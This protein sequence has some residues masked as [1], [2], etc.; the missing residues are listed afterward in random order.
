MM[1]FLAMVIVALALSVSA[2]AQH[3]MTDADARKLSEA[4]SDKFNEDWNKGD[5]KQLASLFTRDATLVTPGG[6]LSGSA[7][8]ENDLARAAGKSVRSATVDEAHAIAANAAWAT[9]SFKVAGKSGN[10]SFGG[11]WASYYRR[12]GKAWK[13]RLFIIN[14]TPPPRPPAPESPAK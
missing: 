7:A 13:M 14:V 3:K 4:M 2:Y 11:F 6:R 5:A 12:D 1:R 8:I 9:G 10:P